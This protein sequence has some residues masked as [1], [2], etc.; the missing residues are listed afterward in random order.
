MITKKRVLFLITVLIAFALII[1][2]F[3]SFTKTYVGKIYPN[4]FLDEVPIGR[5][6]KEE[7]I[8]QFEKNNELLKKVVV[9]IIYENQPIATYSA[10]QLNIRIDT[11]DKINQAYLIGRSGNIK[12]QLYQKIACLLGLKKYYFTSSIFFDKSSIYELLSLSEDKYNKPAKNALFKFEN[13]KV[14]S[15]RQEEYGLKI[16][17]DKL[18]SNLEKKVQEIKL[19]PHNIIIVLE[20]QV[21]KPDVTLSEAN[22]FGIEQKIGE[23][24]SDFTHSTAERIHNIT[25]ATSKFNGVLILKDKEFSFNQTVGDISVNTG[26]QQA[27]IIKSGR[28][29]LGDGGGV[30]QVSTTFFRAALNT[31]L[32]ITE[33]HAHDYRVGYYEND[34]G[35]GFDA[36]V[37]DP[38]ADLKIRN[39]TPGAI[40]IQTEIDKNNNLLYFRL[41]GKKDG[42]EVEISPVT[43]YDQQ[44]PLPAKY[45]DDPTIKKGVTKQVDFPAWGAK[46]KFNYKITRNRQVIFEQTFFSNYH[47]WQAV[48]LVGSAD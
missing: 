7:L 46:A 45:Q 3:N 28:T 24:K 35:P 25:L 41:Y 23:G 38:S 8:G 42:R 13:N 4:I 39:D 5:K 47:P 17:S 36:T 20:N 22:N 18:I 9:N 16:L 44:P 15:F 21:V 31:G 10:S 34:S 29:V 19:T 37:F 1:K 33:R 30:C 48:Y 27:Y 2:Y 40:L 11:F 43:V 14:D 6:N 32:I 12:A 26:Y